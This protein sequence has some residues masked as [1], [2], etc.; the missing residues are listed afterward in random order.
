VDKNSVLAGQFGQADDGV[1]VDPDQSAGLADATTLSKVSQDVDSL[2][3]GK[4]GIEQGRAFAFGKALLAGAAGEHPPLGRAVAEAHPQVVEAAL[5]VVGAIRVL[6][7]EKREVVHGHGSKKKSGML[8][9]N[10]YAYP[11]K[12]GPGR[13]HS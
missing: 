6:A 3:F 13:Q 5:A 11:T 7:A 9:T 2:L 1:F 12:P 8:W 4:A 10:H